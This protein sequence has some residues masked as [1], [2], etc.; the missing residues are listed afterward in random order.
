MNDVLKKK[1]F[2]KKNQVPKKNAV[3][4]KWTPFLL[5]SPSDIPNVYHL[6]QK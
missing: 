5:G 6:K 2:E 1:T 3:L 4:K